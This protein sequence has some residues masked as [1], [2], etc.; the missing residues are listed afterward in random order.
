MI[1][2]I[3]TVLFLSAVPAV[4]L[5]YIIVMLTKKVNHK[6]KVRGENHARKKDK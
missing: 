4:A 2:K 6:G 1:Q 5:V 3:A